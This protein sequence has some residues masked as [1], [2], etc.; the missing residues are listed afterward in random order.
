MAPLVDNPNSGGT[1]TVRRADVY[2]PQ[3]DSQLLTEVC[4]TSGRVAGADVVDL[5]TGSGVVAMACAYLGAR[6][7]VAVDANRAAAQ[8]AEEAGRQAPCPVTVRCADLGDL[9]GGDQF[10]VVTC[11]PPYVPTPAAESEYFTECPGPR[12]AWAAGVDGRDVLDRVCSAAP[13]LLRPGGT[14]LLVQSALADA[15]KTVRQLRSAGLHATVAA[16]RAI[17]FG[18]VLLARAQWLERTGQILPG[19]RTE[20]LVVI[21]ADKPRTSRGAGVA[22]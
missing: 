16:S 2:A 7:V 3:H 13:A 12:H 9:V 5:C 11:N 1:Q 17:P 15:P 4:R 6:S 8:A 10:D 21:R 19:V 22:R 18:P 20:Q 14:L